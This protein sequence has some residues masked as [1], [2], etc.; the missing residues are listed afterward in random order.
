MNVLKSGSICY[1]YTVGDDTLPV[2][3]AAKDLGVTVESRLKYNK[4]IDSIV[5][6][7]RQWVGLLFKCFVARDADTLI[8]AFKVYIRPI[9]EYASNIRS[10][11]QIGLIDKLE[12]VQRRFT[13]RIPGFESLSYSERLSLLNVESLELRRLRADLITTY[14]VIFGLLD[15]SSN[16]FLLHDNS[17]TRGHPY[18]VMLEHCNNNS[19]KQFLPRR[20]AKD[21]TVYQQWPLI[22][23]IWPLSEPACRTLTY[24][25]S[26]I[27]RA[28]FFSLGHTSETKVL[29]VLWTGLPFYTV[30]TFLFIPS[31]STNMYVCNCHFVCLQYKTFVHFSLIILH[32]IFS[33]Y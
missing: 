1:P 29:C 27:F 32:D 22:L 17:V 3:T 4:H 20:I 26:H 5:G 23:L 28:S 10:P 24:A 16:F 31:S 12:S 11:I 2:Q 18:K 33:D 21:W 15:V 7:A 25:Y 6:C 14:K 8:R 30:L 9:L 13:K 19:Q